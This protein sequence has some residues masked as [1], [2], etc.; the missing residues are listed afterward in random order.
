MRRKLFKL[1]MASGLVLLV[2]SF[3]WIGT[4]DWVDAAYAQQNQNRGDGEIHVLPVQG[5]IYMLI[6]G[7]SNITMSVGV[8]GTLLVDAGTAQMSD[9]VLAAV[10][11]LATVVTASSYPPSPCVGFRCPGGPGAGA[12]TPWGWSSPSMNAWISSPSPLKPIRQIINTNDDPEHTGGNLKLAA[13]GKTFVGGNISRGPGG[14]GEGAQILAFETV[15]NRMTEAKVPDAAWPTDTYYIP[16]YKITGFFNGEGIELIHIPAAHT[17][18]DTIVYFRYSDVI[19]AGDVF[20]ID[21]Y[22]VIDLERGGS[23]QGTIDGLNKILDIAI[24]QFRSQGGTYIVPGH[25]RLSDT[26]DVANYRN[27][28]VKIRDRIQDMMKSRM[29]LQQV[30]AANPTLDYDGRFGS[31]D[32][33]IEAVYRSLSQIH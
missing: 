18:G 23:I 6:G 14:T 22:P 27:M 16:K 1:T 17:D 21:S 13:S 30:K 10:K 2:V 5:N 29:T 11:Q 7:G 4:A 26:G 8:D 3:G 19:S 25:G 15:L 28:V 9:K 12:Y 32:K 20:R 24:P 31:P 33:F